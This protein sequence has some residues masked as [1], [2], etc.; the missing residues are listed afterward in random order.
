MSTLL[1]PP[2]R[3]KRERDVTYRLLFVAS[4]ASVL[5]SSIVCLALVPG[6]LLARG[7]APQNS[8]Q[9]AY[10]IQNLH[11][12][13]ALVGRI[14]A[15][16][17]LLGPLSTSTGIVR[18]LSLIVSL[19]PKGVRIVNISYARIRQTQKIMSES[20]TISGAAPTPASVSDYRSAL[21][22]SHAFSSVSVPANALA[23]ASSG[24]FVITVSK[25]LP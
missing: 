7:E 15:L 22:G 20:V 1:P 12:D 6:Y 3:A 25:T 19:R 21:D 16:R 9:V 14:R 11:A 8:L 24:T 18:D 2:E 17:S 13:S 4:C 10:G 23:G 5:L